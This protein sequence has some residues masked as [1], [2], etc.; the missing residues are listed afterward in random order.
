MFVCPYIDWNDV[1]NIKESSKFAKSIS[2]IDTL[3]KE[4]T[5]LALLSDLHQ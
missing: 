4:V 1:D 2:V 3:A 5:M